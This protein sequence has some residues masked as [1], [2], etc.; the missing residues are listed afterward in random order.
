LVLDVVEIPL[1]VALSRTVYIFIPLIDSQCSVASLLYPL[2]QIPAR[3]ATCLCYVL[4]DLRNICF[5]W[6]YN[7]IKLFHGH[8]GYKICS[9][10][11][12][13]HVIH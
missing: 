4:L 8:A 3:A 1:A 9:S 6:A 5:P 10:S 13:N 12:P 7:E 2:L 11:L